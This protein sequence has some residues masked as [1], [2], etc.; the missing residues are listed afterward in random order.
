MKSW[1]RC[2]TGIALA[3]K[4]RREE[5]MRRACRDEERAQ[6][7]RVRAEAEAKTAALRAKEAQQREQA[8][9]QNRLQS[10]A[11]LEAMLQNPALREAEKARLRA[12]AQTKGLAFAF[13]LAHTAARGLDD[14]STGSTR[15][16]DPTSAARQQA[17]QDYRAGER[18]AEAIAAEY[19]TRKAVQ[20]YRQG[21]WAEYITPLPVCTAEN[22]EKPKPWWQRAGEWF[23]QNEVGQRVRN[24]AIGLFSG[25]V[26][27]SITGAIGGAIVGSLAG[28]VGAGPGA[29]G[30]AI[31]GG[32][33]GGL[34]GLVNG[35]LVQPSTPP[36]RVAVQSAIWGGVAGL[37]SGV[38]SV[39]A[40]VNGFAHGGQAWHIGLQTANKLNI[41]HIGVHPIYGFHIAFGAVEPYVADLHIYL[42]KVFPFFRIW[43]P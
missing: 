39:L 19:Q 22:I 13:T 35:L 1:R 2:A 28:G 26:A 31:V 27:G 10:K 17:Y 24:A 11:A 8:K 42:Q 20:D 15:R 5:A 23:N 43:R 33:T 38:G 41:F 7:E 40:G 25:L 3:A 21:E 32:I 34:S 14:V 18:S 37:L 29:L 9:I 12:E 16:L 30:G 6:A 36:K 4:R